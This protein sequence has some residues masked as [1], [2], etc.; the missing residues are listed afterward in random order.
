[1]AHGSSAVAFERGSKLCFTDLV[2]LGAMQLDADGDSGHTFGWINIA[3]VG[4]WQGHP[5]GPFEFTTELFETLIA[6]ADKRSTP[7]NFDYEHQSF[8]EDVAGPKPS[9]GAVQKLELRASGN[10]LWAFVRWTPRATQLIKAGE[11]RSCSPVVTFDRTDRRSGKPIGADLLSVALTND[12]FLDG[13]H[14]VQLTRAAAMRTAAMSDGATVSAEQEKAAELAAKALKAKAMADAS[15]AYDAEQEKAKTMA[16]EKT[17]E[18]TAA[19]EAKAAEETKAKEMAD[20]AAAVDGD[21]LADE[22]PAEE[23]AAGDVSPDATALLGSIADKSGKSLDEVMGAL[24]DNLDAVVAIVTGSRDGTIADAAPMKD[25]GVAALTLRLKAQ[26]DVITQ[27][28]SSVAVLTADRD[29][30]VK[31][32]EES[33]AAERKLALHDKVKQ[34]QATGFVPE[35]EKAFAVALKVHETLDAET[36]ASVYST[37]I[38]PLKLDIAGSDPRGNADTTTVATDGLNDDERATVRSLMGVDKSEKDAVQIVALMRD[39]TSPAE[40]AK[41]VAAKRSEKGAK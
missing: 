37:Q 16:A 14:P 4:D 35:G 10:E 12:P 38:V 17:P 33:A 9:S 27:L 19:E 1:M 41:I 20:G 5:S 28:K 39:G 15:D 3:K 29:K 36:A 18:E 32:A 24:M 8:N 26:N 2:A 11:Y 23:V 21:K 40:A 7:I 30:R 22:T 25:G 34:L 13:L 6:N 31:A